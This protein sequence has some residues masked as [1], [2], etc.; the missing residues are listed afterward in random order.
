MSIWAAQGTQTAGSKTALVVVSTAAIRPRI[1]E[2]TY[3]NVG[4]VTVDSQFEIQCKRFTAAGTT[5]AVTPAPTDPSEGTPTM[6]FGSNATVEPTYTAN[7]T[8]FD[9]GVNPRG[10]F[11][12][13]AYDPS[14]EIILPAAAANGVGYFVN[15]LGG[16]VTIIV[17]AKVRQ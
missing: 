9:T 3:S 1:L 13:T 16:A 6:T 12:W 14:A 2:H 15:A 11:R 10:I 7:T 8:L 4:A 17:D 5:T